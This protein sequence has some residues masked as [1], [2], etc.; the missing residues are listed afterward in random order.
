MNHDLFSPAAAVRPAEDPAALLAAANAEHEA[1]LRAERASL[2]HYRKAG[3]ALLRAKAAAGHGKWLPLLKERSSI[4]NQR[5]SEY[6]RLAAGWG[7]IPPG[8]NFT[9]KQA[10]RIIAGEPAEEE[11]ETL[12]ELA[13]QIREL[14][15]H[16]VM[17]AIRALDHRHKLGLLVAEVFALDEGAAR[18]ALP[19]LE[20]SEDEARRLMN[21]AQQH[22]ENWEP[23]I[24]DADAYIDGKLDEIFAKLGI[25][26]DEADE[27]IPE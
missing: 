10:L 16:I 20:M 5:A 1:G 9:L 8:G 26:L 21:W 24:K 11:G 6:M 13:K 18:A 3:D 7:K 23:T 19:E 17:N 15:D 27:A 12:D 2:E 14:H 25:P 4:S 22:G